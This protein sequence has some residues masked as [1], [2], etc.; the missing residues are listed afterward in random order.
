[1]SYDR[2]ITVFS[3]DGHLH[4]V[5]YAMQAVQKGSSTIA[6]VGKECVVLAVEKK[7]A[8]A[9]QDTLRMEK[10]VKIDSD[11]AL[12]FSG[13][14]ADA[15]VL[16][17]KARLECQRHAL[18]MSDHPNVK[19]IARYIART[20]QRY[21]QRG[22]VRPFGLSTLIGGFEIDGTPQL[23]ATDPAG[24]HT[25]WRATA[26]GKNYKTLLE[27]LEKNYKDDMSDDETIT[28][29]LKTL[30]EVVDNPDQNIELMCLKHKQPLK[31][32]PMDDVQQRVKTIIAEEEAA[33][34]AAEEEEMMA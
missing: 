32:L 15:R 1:M 34:K 22:G 8:Q 20:Q 28:M 21:T 13:L 30:C 27:Y 25:A 31:S 12:A 3:P 9:L 16:I 11:K 2:A 24:V 5:E 10:I 23:H 6:L 19:Q 26:I 17:D 4:Q 18:T 33:K 29:A 7:A 14:N